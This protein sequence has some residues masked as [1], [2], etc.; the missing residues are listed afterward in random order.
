MPAQLPPASQQ[1]VAQRRVAAAVADVPLPGRDDLE[2]LVALFVELDRAGHRPRLAVEVAGGAQQLDDPFP[3]RMHRLA[4][5]LVV[6][7][8][9]HAGRR[10]EDEPA[11]PADDRPG[12]QVELPPP[13]HVSRVA[14]RTDHGDARAFVRLGEVMRDHRDLDAEQRG[15]HGAP[16]QRPIALVVRMCDERDAR[17]DQLR[18][19]RL[20]V[21]RASLRPMEGDPVERTRLLTIFELGLG[22]G[23]TERHVPQR[24]GLSGVGLA[25]GQVAQKRALRHRSRRVADRGV[26]RGPVDRQADP[27]PDLLERLFV[28]LG[29]PVAQLHE[30]A[31]G[32]GKLAL[33][34]LVRRLE[35]GIVGQRGIAADA[36]VI[37]DAALGRQ[38]VV[39]PPHRVEDLP[40]AHPPKAR[41]RVGVGVGEDVP[42]VQ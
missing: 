20:D 33:A 40:A 35:A 18:P 28:V 36:E 16:E 37:L 10:L 6:G 30:V 2:R 25:T 38:S 24:G 19:G 39:V 29:E 14:E 13:R 5:E 12:R 17:R 23:G 3:R 8:G 27:A 7:P 32:D 21:H 31:P 41:H 15:A 42:D 11:V 34:R 1:P 4:G 26:E 9:G 22:H